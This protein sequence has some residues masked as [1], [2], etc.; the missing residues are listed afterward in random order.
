[1]TVTEHPFEPS[2]KSPTAGN[3]RLVWSG[4]VFCTLSALVFGVLRVPDLPAHFQ[5]DGQLAEY[6]AW[7]QAPDQFAGTI[8]AELNPRLYSVYYPLIATLHQYVDRMTLLTSLYVGEL[9]LLGLATFVCGWLLV[10]DALAAVLLS[11]AVIWG[12][13]LATTLGGGG[14]VG[15]VCNPEYP[16]TAMIVVALGWS[17][18]GRHRSAILLSAAAFNVHGS[19]AIFGA[20]LVFGAAVLDLT[21]QRRWGRLVQVTV[22]GLA[23][24]APTALW[25]LRDMPTGGAAWASNMWWQFP[26]WIYPL[27]I[28]VSTSPWQLWFGFAGLVVPALVGWQSIGKAFS[29]RHAILLGWS[30]AAVVLLAIGYVLVEWYPIRF[31]AQLALWRGTRFVLVVALAFGLHWLITQMQTGGVRAWVAPLA[32]VGLIG[33]PVTALA[34][35]GWVALSLLTVMTIQG[36]TRH[37]KVLTVLAVAVFGLLA[38]PAIERFSIELAFGMRLMLCLLVVTAVWLWA[39]RQV[40]FMRLLS[41]A[42]AVLALFCFL[43]AWHLGTHLSTQ[44]ATEARELAELAPAIER[45]SNRGEL[46]VASPTLRNPGAWANR[47]SFLCRQQ[48]TAY[49]YGPWLVPELIE[50]MQCIDG[51]VD[52]S[53]TTYSLTALAEKYDAGDGAMFESLRDRYG[54]RLAITNREKQLPFRRVALNDTFSVYDLA[55]AE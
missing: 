51:E 35:A 1:M 3:R 41:A 6:L 9:M 50:R 15:I 7:T 22:L 32:V 11:T 8:N 43:H 31:I 18:R 28:Y 36:R 47:G 12:N 2:S 49:A 13:V 42:T 4:A 25:A 39:A 16:A 53:L 27:H 52:A 5:W 17:F 33:V 45:H 37:G 54:V 34:A 23:A 29:D 20:G 38:W 21:K 30:L 48:L 19:L 46:V 40:R 44:K 24:A 14:G 26:H 10:R 55:A